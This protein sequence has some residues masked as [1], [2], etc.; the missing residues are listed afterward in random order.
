MTILIAQMTQ[1]SNMKAIG[2]I[3]NFKQIVKLEHFSM[4][5]YGE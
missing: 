5:F 3:V 2:L 1:I 4:E